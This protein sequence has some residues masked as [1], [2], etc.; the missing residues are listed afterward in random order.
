MAQVYDYSWARPAPAALA[1]ECIGVARYLAGG[2]GGGKELTKAEAAALHAHG[3]GIAVVWETTAQR[4]LSGYQGGYADGVR[5]RAQM[6]DLGFPEG[7]TCYAAVDFQPLGGQLQTVDDYQHGFRAAQGASTPYGCYDVV[8]LARGRGFRPAWQCA[9]WSGN[10]QGSGGSVQGRRVSSHAALFQ[11]VGYVM[12]D[13]C[14]ANDVLRSDWGGWYPGDTPT[15]PEDDMAKPD[16]IQRTSDGQAWLLSPYAKVATKLTGERVAQLAWVG[17]ED[18]GTLPATLDW[19]VTDI[20]TDTAI[21]KGQE[22]AV[23]R[24]SDGQGWLID[25]LRYPISNDRY[26]ALVFFGVKDRGTMPKE[27]DWLVLELHAN[28]AAAPATGGGGSVPLAITL[29]GV[30]TPTA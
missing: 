3:L 4:P 21:A 19:V 25:G 13:T 15:T 1:R 23:A 12:N 2:G 26:A 28:A 27:L 17:V 7:H 8:E 11:R 22:Q 20:Y 6:L 16:F 30:G 5:A 29:T 24:T 14:D 18:K 10:G 9:A